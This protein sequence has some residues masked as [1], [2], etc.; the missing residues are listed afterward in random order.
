MIVGSAVGPGNSVLRTRRLIVGPK[1]AA[2]T[3]KIARGPDRMPAERATE[4]T[5]VERAA[6]R[7]TRHLIVA[8]KA[9][10][11]TRKI[12]RGPD[13]MPAARATEATCVK[14][15]AIRLTV[16]LIVA[17]KAAA[18]TRKIARSPRRMKAAWA[19]EAALSEELLDFSQL[20][21]IWSILTHAGRE[22]SN[23]SKHQH[24]KSLIGRSHVG[25]LL[26]LQYGRRRSAASMGGR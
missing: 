14:G 4:A 18:A 11:A 20:P 15:A 24:D 26:D 5:C 9:A 21:F 6:I 7:R 2:A 22:S 23:R 3:Q 10:A 25:I 16:H 19:T 8:P 12:A 13:R 17:P 1:A